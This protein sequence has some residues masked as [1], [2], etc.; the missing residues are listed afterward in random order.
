MVPEKALYWT[1]VSVL[2]LVAGN[3]FAAR[4]ADGVGCFVSRSLAVIQQVSGHTTRLMGTAEMTLGRNGAHFP[5]AQGKLACAQTRLA[6]VQ[7]V[8]AQ[9]EAAFAQVQAERAQLAVLQPLRGASICPRQRLR[10]ATPRSSRD[11]TI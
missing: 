4:Q 8:I 9:H 3:H 7:A 6:S 10:I 5:T 11:G 1:A 2:A